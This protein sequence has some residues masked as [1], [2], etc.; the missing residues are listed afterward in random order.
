MPF[1]EEDTWRFSSRR[2]YATKT[3]SSAVSAVTPSTVM[4]LAL[5]KRMRLVAALLLDVEAVEGVG[6]ADLLDRLAGQLAGGLGQ[7]R[8]LEPR[9]SLDFDQVA[10]R[11]AEVPDGVFAPHR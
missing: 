10:L 4:L 2:R 6:H 9:G 11:R 5:S 1:R 3:K 7:D 8:H